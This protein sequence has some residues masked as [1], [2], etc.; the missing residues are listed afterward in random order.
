LEE[1]EILEAIQIGRL[2]RRGAIG[3]MDQLASPLTGKDAS[4]P[5][6]ECPLRSTE[7]DFTE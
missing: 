7:K 5:E 3:K 6:E 2:A 1:K 4:S